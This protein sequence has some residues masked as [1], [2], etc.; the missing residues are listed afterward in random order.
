MDTEKEVE[1]ARERKRV[2]AQKN[3]CQID[4]EEKRAK[5]MANAFNSTFQMNNSNSTHQNSQRWT[6]LIL[7][8]FAPPTRPRPLFC[9]TKRN[10]MKVK[11]AIET[12]KLLRISQHGMIAIAA[13][14]IKERYHIIWRWIS[15]SKTISIDDRM[16]ERNEKTEAREIHQNWS[17]FS[18]LKRE[19]M[20]AR[21]QDLFISLSHRIHS[22]KQHRSSSMGFWHTWIRQLSVIDE[23][24]F[25]LIDNTWVC[26]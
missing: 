2:C 4:R 26:V 10:S 5:D 6:G 3:W 22:I 7:V 9:R 21:S 25:H 1:L 11:W 18:C 15:K 13:V 19:C 20:S 23:Y 14:K 12:L 8:A 16:R 17:N 24:N